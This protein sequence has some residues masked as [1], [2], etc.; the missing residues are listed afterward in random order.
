MARVRQMRYVGRNLIGSLIEMTRSAKSI[1]DNPYAGKRKIHEETLHE[2]EAYAKRLGISEIG[3]T[4]VNTRYIFNGFRILFRNAIVFT[5]EMDKYK[6]NLSPSIPSFIEVFRTYYQ[7]GVVVNKISEFMRERGYNAHAGPAV[8]GDANYIP[9]AIDAGLGYSGKN[10][11]LITRK[12]GPRVRLAAV[13]TDIENLPFSKNNDQGWVREF[14]GTCNNC[15]E[16]CPA[17]A[18]F[19]KP[20]THKDG[21]PYF[22][23]HRKCAVPFSNENGCTLCVKYCP[24]SYAAY[25]R[26]KEKFKESKLNPISGDQ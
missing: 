1:T 15:I 21:G 20:R 26:L 6:I 19:M 5:I 8:G 10:G 25:D 17:E 18:I 16:K 7:V 9:L 11:L 23:D 14:C 24:F 3:Y 22:I 4:R 12:N 2:L 13:Y